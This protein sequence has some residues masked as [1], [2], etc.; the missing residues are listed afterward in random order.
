M[1]YLNFDQEGER[2][3]LLTVR[4]AVDRGHAV[5]TH[6]VFTIMAGVSLLGL[7]IIGLLDWPIIGLALVLGSPL[8]AWVWWS[9]A[10]PRWRHWALGR[11]VNAAHLQRVAEQERLVW[12]QGHLFE[13]TEFRF[14]RD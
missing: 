12:P 7:G 10:T 11:G 4:A 1:G 14:P 6:R 5:I 3:D 8:I 9:Y 13:R 2:S